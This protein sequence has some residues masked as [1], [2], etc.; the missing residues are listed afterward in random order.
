MYILIKTVSWSVCIIVFVLT[1]F[2]A[3]KYL[4]GTCLVSKL[5]FS[6]PDS[7]T[8]HLDIVKSDSEFSAKDKTS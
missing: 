2:N 3:D 6:I 5:K 8:N 7:D 1:K 4:K